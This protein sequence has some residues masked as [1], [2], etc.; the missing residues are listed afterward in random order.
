[1]VIAE[2]SAGVTGDLDRQ[3]HIKSVLL[4]AR[5]AALQI[6]DKRRQTKI[7]EQIAE[8]QAKAGDYAGAVQ[9]AIAILPSGRVALF[10]TVRRLAAEGRAAEAESLGKQLW[11]GTISLVECDCPGP[12]T[13]GEDQGSHPDLRID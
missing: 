11:G 6:E 2:A 4:E 13:V 10:A 9:T 8:T 5:K 12:S 3:S 1:L 7:L